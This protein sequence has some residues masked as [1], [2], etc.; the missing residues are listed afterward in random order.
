M[1]KYSVNG[2]WDKIKNVNML[3][4]IEKYI[5]VMKNNRL[6]ISNLSWKHNNNLDMIYKLKDYGI[7]SLEI[8][9]YKYFGSSIDN[10]D[11]NSITNNV[12]IYSFQ[13]ILY[14]LNKNIFHSDDDRL[15]IKNCLYK[16]IDV[17]IKLNVKILV[18]GSPKNRKRNNLSYDN[19]L[20][21]AISFFKEIGDYA[22]A[23]NVILCIEPNAKIYGCDFITNSIEG[24]ELVLK[25]NSDGF[26][27]HLDVG[28]MFLE[29][30]DILEC[31]T[32]NLDIL[33][34]IHFSAPE[35]KS[36]LYNRQLDYNKLY[37][38]IIKIYDGKIAIEML[39]CDDH[40]VMR[41]VRNCLIY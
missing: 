24:R 3:G 27:L 17:A 1:T 33:K 25:V 34:H 29:N 15:D 38:E 11:I 20:E 40:E 32:L 35:L 5:D 21:I 13:S 14:P 4:K 10:I 41:N 16:M 6:I 28:C 26:K 39:N 8:A 18:F 22:Y 7:N 19:A 37:Q 23:N 30:E 12:N 2:Y 36:L 31:I 9:P